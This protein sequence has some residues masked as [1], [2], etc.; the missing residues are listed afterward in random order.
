MIPGAYL[1]A[2]AGLLVQLAAPY[3]FSV[4]EQLTYE[5]KLGYLPVGT[6]SVTV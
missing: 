5:A 2:H 1:V 4:G 3:P 6:A